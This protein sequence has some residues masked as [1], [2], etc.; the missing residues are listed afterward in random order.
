[1]KSYL[2]LVP[3][4]AKVHKRRNRMTLFCIV[5]AVFLVTAVFSMANM[6]LRLEKLHSIEGH[7]NWHIRLSGLS[8][9]DAQLIGARLDV[10]AASWYDTVNLDMD[11]DYEIGGFQTALCGIDQAFVTDI[12]SY[13]TEGSCLQDEGQIILTAN[14]RELLGTEEGDT[15][16]LHT[17]RGS[18]DFTVSGF[19]SDSERYTMGTRGEETALLVKDDQ[20]GAFMDIRAFRTILG[21]KNQEESSPVYYIQFKNHTNMKKAI[22]EIMEQYGLTDKN[23]EQNTIVMGLMGLADNTYAKNWYSLAAVLFVLILAAGVLMI[24]SSLNSNIAERTQFFGMLRCIG[25]SRQ[26]IIRFVRLEALSWCRTAV[27]IGIVSGIL[28]TWALCAALRFGVGGEFSDMPLFGVSV[29]GIF[30]GIVVGFVT[31]LIAAQSPAKRA[32]KVSPMAAVSGNAENTANVRH[33]AHT[34]FGRIETALGIHHAV[35][36]KKN[37]FLMTGSFALTIILFFSFSVLI[38]AVGCLLPQKT[39][40]PDLSIVSSDLSNALDRALT[41]EISGQQGIKRAF[42]RMLKSDVP[43]GFSKSMKQDTID[44]LSYDEYQLSCIPKDEGLRKGSD[45]SK[46]YG[47]SGY[48]LTIYDRENPLEIGDKIRIGEEEV[49]I[50]GI[51]RYSPFSDDGSTNGKIDVICSEE[52][53]VRL[54]GESR[55]AIIDIQMSKDAE[56]EDAERIHRLADD[57]ACTFDDRWTDSEQNIYLV[58]ILFVYGFLAIIALISALNIINSVSMSVSARIRQYGAMR[59]VGM[60]GGQVT[61]M[62]GAETLTYTCFGCVIG[63]AVGLPLNKFLYDYVITSHFYYFTWSVPVG[64][65]L[66]ILL[67][68]FASSAAAVY[69]PAKRIRNMA[70]TDTINEL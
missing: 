9:N 37:L 18:H 14:A 2:S 44:L 29:I 41:E 50:A 62:I 54:T 57:L 42:G 35:S 5:L 38:E 36:A 68:I 66:I 48:V 56:E 65:L 34:R 40:S 61:R 51:L 30:S 60:D 3:I 21:S 16:T 22:A 64:L 20:I 25:A 19:R 31:V 63:C 23:I 10:A 46:V 8:E 47:D 13:F 7:G 55:Y 28:V 45:L 49:E 12:M 6:A 24:S 1:M 67:F 59:A 70:V 69:A 39:S 26:Q 33:A 11:K 52:T 4:S 32:A 58:F 43:A 17:P 53:F 27:P 15:V